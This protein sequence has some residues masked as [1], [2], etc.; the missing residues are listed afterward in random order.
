MQIFA[1]YT[2]RYRARYCAYSALDQEL[3]ET[4]SAASSKQSRRVGQSGKL[5]PNV[6]ITGFISF[7]TYRLAYKQ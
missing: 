1:G 5:Q 2:Q 3:T 6:A 4:Y 7:P